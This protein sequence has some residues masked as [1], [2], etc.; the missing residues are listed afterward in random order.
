MIDECLEQIER[1]GWQERSHLAEVLRLKGWMLTQGKGDAEAPKRASARSIDWAREQQA[2]ILGA[3]QLD[4]AC[5]AVASAASATPRVSCLPRS[6]T[7]SP[8]ASTRAT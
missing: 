7:G 8:K 2:K 5:A 3:A 4:Y 6:T 1:P